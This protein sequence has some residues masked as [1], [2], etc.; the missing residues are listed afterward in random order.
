M[1]MHLCFSWCFPLLKTVYL[2]GH[3]DTS[4]CPYTYIYIHIHLVENWRLRSRLI[5]FVRR[6]LIAIAPWLLFHH[7]NL[8]R[9]CLW[10][11]LNSRCSWI[12]RVANRLRVLYSSSKKT[13]WKHFLKFPENFKGRCAKTHEAHFH[14][15]WKT[16]FKKIHAAFFTVM[17]MQRLYEF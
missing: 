16:E 4:H 12:V 9:T 15:P 14:F 17:S 7:P 11:K 6:E 8:E 5:E 13:F 3:R 2:I 1:R 10:L